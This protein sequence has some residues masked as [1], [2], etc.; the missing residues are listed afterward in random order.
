MK[1]LVARA[2]IDH[3][4]GVAKL[5]EGLNIPIEGA[6]KDDR[7]WIDGLAATSQPIWLGRNGSLIRS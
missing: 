7:F 3:A 2:H 1:I 5:K 6:H 4:G